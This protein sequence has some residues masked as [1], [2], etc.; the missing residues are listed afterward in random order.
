MNPMLKVLLVASFVF[1]FTARADVKIPPGLLM[2]VPLV[3]QS[4]NY[5]CGPAALL[6]VLSYYGFENH[7]ETELM[8]MAGT[9]VKDGTDIDKLTEV[10]NRIGLKAS[11]RSELTLADLRTSLAKKNPVIVALQAWPDKPSTVPF[12]EQFDDGHYVVVIGL[13]A[14]NNA[15]NIFFEDPAYLGGRGHIPLPEFIERWHDLV[16]DKIK[17]QHAGIFFEGTPNPPAAWTYVP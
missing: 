4:T 12:S 2:D 15:E 6:A 7:L 9:T 16:G 5:S 13:D 17:L 3:R 8:Q 11:W 14:E 1:T 10:A